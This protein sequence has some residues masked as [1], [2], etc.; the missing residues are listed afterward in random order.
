[1]TGSGGSTNAPGSGDEARRRLVA[2]RD[3]LLARIDAV[4]ADRAAGEM[5]DLDAETLL[6]DL[7]ARAAEVI[8]ALDDTD[9][10][11][12]ESDA[13]AKRRSASRRS[14]GRPGG[15]DTRP[16]T[17]T[18][19][20]PPR[21][22]RRL[23]WVGGVVVV[24]LV[25]GAV[26][27]QSTGRRGTGETFTG[28]IRQTTRDLL[29]EARDQTAAGDF[30]AA[31]ATYDEVLAIAPTNAE[32][33]TYRAWVGRTMAGALP[34]EEALTLLDD[35]LASDPAYGDALVFKAIILRDLG[36]FEEAL[37][38]LDALEA[39]GEGAV[40]QFLVDRVAGLRAEVSGA[41]PDTRDLIRAQASVRAGDYAAALR[42]LDEVLARSPGNVEALVAKADVLLVVASG[43]QGED[44][45]LLVGNALT[46]IER[47]EM[48]APGDPV[49]LLY[50]TLV[51]ELL[52]RIDEARATLDRIEASGPLDEQL[53]A[54]VAALRQRIG[55]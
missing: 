14:G 47:A 15:A 21:R 19:S 46:L 24:A 26:L 45:N 18:T 6:D 32:A 17:S 22:T 54:Q 23:L 25:A 27:V 40:P 34:D 31:L 44:R 50:R 49:P 7:T 9:E 30:E 38:A 4:E 52:G 35:A 51:L 2:E 39:L 29:L 13:S 37:V 20:G 28:D 10:A 43:T 48:A 16:S 36:R 5:D 53:A 1:M 33:L 3:E 11:S 42:I 41:G 8:R 12:A 55:D